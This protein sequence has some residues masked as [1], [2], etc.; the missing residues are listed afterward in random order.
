M[1]PRSLGQVFTPSWLADRLADDV[2][3]VSGPVLD[4]A[5]GDGSL[6]VA[7]CRARLAR[8]WSPERAVG[9]VQGWD[10]DPAAAAACRSALRAL[11]G[12]EP[13]VYVGDALAPTSPDGRPCGEPRFDAVIMNPPFVE[14]KRMGDE[15]GLR[16][17][18]RAWFPDARG[19]FD[20]YVPFLWRAMG[21]VR[22]AGTVAAILPGKVLQARYAAPLRRAW[23]AEPWHLRTLIDLTRCQPRPFPGTSVYPCVV[24]VSRAAG[25]LVA[26]RYLRPENEEI[27]GQIDAEELR[28]IGG[29]QPLFVPFSTWPALAPL[30][31]L[32]RLG[33][34]A[35][36]VSTCSF[37]HTGLREQFVTPTRPPGEAFRYLGGASFAG[38]LE[39]APYRVRWG[40][41]W[42]SGAAWPG[43]RAQK[44][45]LPDREAVFARPKL[46]LAQH[47]TRPLV[48]IDRDGF[49]TKDTYPV[50]RPTD[51]RWSLE[52][53]CAVLGSTV[54]AA[55]YN[56][57]FQGVLVG[58]DTY[59]Y[60][61]A[62]LHQVPVPRELTALDDVADEVRALHVGGDSPDP[63]ALE[64]VDQAVA[65]AY[66][67]READRQAMIEVH[68]TRPKALRRGAA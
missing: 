34:I 17:R 47:A 13:V 46:V 9:A 14:A 5:C 36:F 7:L 37:H 66:G 65:R 45:A 54:F 42:I 26:S 23:L 28:R 2:I 43:A 6:L 35:K 60:L 22:N 11:G 53:T 16:E 49:V 33:E 51:P 68:L 12:G 3:G 25:P 67:V 24:S 8:G 52:A 19:A 63:D 15:P 4:P 58:G 62:F 27:A 44:N 18:L 32:P 56:T 48:V 55:L 59:H 21:L 61:P 39:V 1:A 38:Q 50:G 31:S 10:R 29:E 64:R 41:W 30:L 40:G 57:L 20:L